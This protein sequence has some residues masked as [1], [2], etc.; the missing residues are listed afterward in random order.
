VYLAAPVSVL[1]SSKQQVP[2]GLNQQ[3]HR[4]GTKLRREQALIARQ[5]Q[6]RRHGLVTTNESPAQSLPSVKQQPVRFV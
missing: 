5:G 2:T 4:S 1:G 6:Y 3:T